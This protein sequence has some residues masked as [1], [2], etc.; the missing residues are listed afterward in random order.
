[1]SSTE[2]TQSQL[3]AY[4]QLNTI[5]LEP[6]KHDRLICVDGRYTRGLHDQQDIAAPG[7]HLGPIMALLDSQF[8][9]SPQA[10]FELVEG[11]LASTK[12]PFIWHTDTHE[13]HGD[14]KIGCGHCNA[15]INHAHHYGLDAARVEEMV[16]IV[17]AYQ[18]ERQSDRA[19]ATCP[20]CTLLE[21]DHQE[22]AVIIVESDQY[23]IEH[24]GENEQGEAEQYFVYDATL[25]QQFLARLVE[26]VRSQGREIDL[27]KLLKV[28]EQ[29]TN[30]TLSL[31]PSSQ[32]LPIYQ[33]S[34]DD[35]GNPQS[36]L[37][38][39]VEAAA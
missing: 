16:A 29:Q 30:T 18:A 35:G 22:R 3:E 1:M 11:F 33:V 34:F 28:V 12:T 6:G 9:L 2:I 26:W 37:V 4:L 24:C 38:G 7:A 31:L 15:A 25:Y 36:Q 27:E 39:R 20:T 32:G 23:T 21:L 13:G 8:D 5:K 14:C 17:R 19:A 10:A